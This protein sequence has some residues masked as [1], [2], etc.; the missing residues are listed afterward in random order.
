LVGSWSAVAYGTSGPPRLPPPGAVRIVTREVENT[1]L[2]QITT[3][4]SIPY[5]VHVQ[6]GAMCQPRP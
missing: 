4:K 1:V 3:A 5:L 2:A 6:I